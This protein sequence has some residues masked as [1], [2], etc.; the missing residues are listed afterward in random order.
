MKIPR[1]A[2]I[3]P[4]KLTDYLLSRRPLDDK[5]RFLERAGFTKSEPEILENAIRQLAIEEEAVEG[6]D[7]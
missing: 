7:E 6:R 5:S 2:I 4:A 1:D 3:P